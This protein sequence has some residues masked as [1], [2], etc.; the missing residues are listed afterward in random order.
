MTSLLLT[1]P[2]GLTLT[3]FDQLADVAPEL[4]WLANITKAKTHRAD[5]I[6]VSEFFAFAG[7][8]PW[9]CAASPARM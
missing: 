2:S 1:N 7:K 6:A 8:V 9:S 4:E 5:R 3:Q